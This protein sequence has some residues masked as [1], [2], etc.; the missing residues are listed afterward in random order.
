MNACLLI[1]YVLIFAFAKA[2]FSQ[3]F[4]NTSN[5]IAGKYERDPAKTQY[6]TKNEVNAKLNRSLTL[7]PEV[8]FEYHGSRQLKGQ[9][10]E[11]FYGRGSWFLKGKSFTLRQLPK[12]L[13]PHTP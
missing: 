2:G 6:D 1:C 10:K 4:T 13:M 8:R 12:I 7:S 3:T 9:E 5:D 11:N